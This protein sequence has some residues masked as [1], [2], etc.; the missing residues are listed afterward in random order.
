MAAFL[1]WNV[2]KRQLDGFVQNLVQQHD[3]D[4]VLLVEYAFGSSELPRLLEGD[5]LRKRLSH[6]R[7]GVF[8]R[9]GHTLLPLRYRI[10]KRVGLWR[11][12]PPSGQEG[13]IVLL[14]GPDR[15][16]YDDGTRRVFF[17][18]VADAV[19]RCEEKRGHKR[20]IVV[21]DFNANPYES[22]VPA[23]DGLHA[24]GVRAV[25]ADTS[26]NVAASGVSID[27]FYNPM[28]RAYGHR[29]HPD[30]GAATHYWVKS[31]A[32]EPGWHMLDQVVLRPGES[33][34]FP[35]E[36]LRIVTRVGEIELLD[37]HGIPDRRTGSD[38]LPI[39]F[40]WDL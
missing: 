21:G 38:H 4:I 9:A 5:G 15:V 10:G 14:H 32:H 36:H 12:S 28:W 33:D 11:W 30:A 22:A 34:R 16:H 23:S 6:E 8:S 3:I 29:G 39:I 7:F 17:R 40:H 31:W 37:Q 2:H 20:T 19:R 13:L 24:I 18:R 1:L 35:E 27:F 26:R 25:R